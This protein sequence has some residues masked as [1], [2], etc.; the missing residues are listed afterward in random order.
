MD[1][2][3]TFV[4]GLIEKEAARLIAAATAATTAGALKLAEAFG[5]TLDAT[6]LAA[7]GTIAALVATEL[8]RRFVYSIKTTQAIADRAEA[9]GDTD[10]GNP[11]EGPQG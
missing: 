5:V 8:I 1:T 7:V 3:L 10:I 11:P 4:K 2:V 9:T 6:Q